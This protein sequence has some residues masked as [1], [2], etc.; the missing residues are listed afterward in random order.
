MFLAL[1]LDQL[2]RDAPGGER[3]VSNKS[4]CN[5]C[6]ARVLQSRL[7]GPLRY[8]DC[9]LRLLAHR[10]VF[11]RRRKLARMCRSGRDED[12]QLDVVAVDLR[13]VLITHPAQARKVLDGIFQ[14]G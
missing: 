7:S 4:S 13:L 10:L 2:Q 9:A 3:V 14:G 11:R 8:E 1:A 5:V 12:Q 6:K